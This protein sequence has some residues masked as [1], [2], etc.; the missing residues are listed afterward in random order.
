MGSTEADA[1]AT[2][3]SYF[4]AADYGESLKAALAGLGSAPDDVE[5]LVIAGRAEVELDSADAVEHLRRATELAPGDAPSWHH[6]GEALAAEGQMTEA[7]AAFRKAVEID[8]DDQVALTHLGHTALAAGRSDEGVGHLARA[9]DIAHGASTAAISLVDMYRSFGQFE[10]ALVQARR[11]A[12]SAQE[13]V[14]AW[15]DVAELSLALSEL[16]ESRSAWERVRELDEIPGHESYPLHGLIQVELHREDFGR[17][18]EL[19]TDVAAIEPQGLS[20]EVAAFLDAKLGEATDGQPPTRDEI[21]SALSASLSEYR[22][23]LA[24]DRRLA[25]GDTVG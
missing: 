2:A 11:L 23:M 1:R 3:R 4:D 9:A 22:R 5:L 18:R 13:D 7:D 15:L 14:L 17:A 19:V 16:D 21:D 6:L 12:G 8:P 25:A 20:T 24:D 10:D